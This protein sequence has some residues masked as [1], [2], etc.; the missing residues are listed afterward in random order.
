[1]LDDMLRARVIDFSVIWDSFLPLVE[2]SSNDNYHASIV[3]PPFEL[4]YDM[5]C[6]TLVCWGE[7]GH[8]VMGKTK[9]VLKNNRACPTYQEEIVDNSESEEELCQKTSIE[10]G[11]PG[12]RYGFTE[13]INLEGCDK[14]EKEEKLGDPIYRAVLSS[15]QGRQGSLSAGSP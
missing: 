1:M 3:A 6:C 13:G 12:R 4:I 7:A 8:W 9:A 10:I 15:G 11:I 2:F 5:K 14:L